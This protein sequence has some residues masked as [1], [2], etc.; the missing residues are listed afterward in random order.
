M[1]NVKSY[2]RITEDKKEAW[3][4]LC[5]PDDG[6]MYEK[7]EIM[8]YLQLNNVVAGINESHVAAMCKKQIYEREVKVASSVKGDPGREGYFEFFFDTE[9]PKPKIN[10][11]G[12]VDYRSMSFK[13]RTQS[14]YDQRRNRRGFMQLSG[15]RK[16]NLA[17]PWHLRG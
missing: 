7:S 2:V 5:A 11:D 13:S 4:Y 1:V 10:S 3:L 8:R 17:S 6:E 12:T 14:R 9:K 15:G 16:S